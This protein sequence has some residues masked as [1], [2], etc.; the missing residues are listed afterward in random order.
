MDPDIS[1]ESTYKREKM[2]VFDNVFSEDNDTNYVCRQ[3]MLPLLDNVVNGYNATLFAYGMTGAGK[4]H[5]LFGELD[6]ETLRVAKPGLIF[7]TL[8]ELFAKTQSPTFAD[9]EFSIKVS[10]LEIYNE[11][12]RDLLK[13]DDQ[14]LMILEDPQRGVLVADLLESSVS[15]LSE[16]MQLI[17]T[18]NSK[19]TMASTSANTF[20]SRSH[21]IV[22]VLVE[23]KE[24]AAGLKGV[25]LQS[26]LSLID[27]AGSERAAVTENRGIRMLEGANINRSLLALG[28][29]INILS[30]SQK[31]GAFVPYRDSK[32]TRL[33]KDSLGGNTKT[34]MIACVSPSYLCYEETVNTL[35]Y[36]S[37][38]KN[39]K[40]KLHQNVKEVELHVSQYKEII[41]NLKAEIDSL[42]GQLKVKNTEESFI[43][44]NQN[45]EAPSP[46]SLES[47]KALE[48]EKRIDQ[49]SHKIFENLEQN[50]EI[51]QTLRELNELELQN[52][53]TLQNLYQHLEHVSEEDR[54]YR[55]QILRQIETLKTTMDSNE[56]IKRETANT[57]QGNLL[58]NRNL[59]EQLIEFASSVDTLEDIELAKKLLDI[60]RLDM[61]TQ[62]TEI[63]KQALNLAKAR[64][65]QN[66]QISQME[67]EMRQMKA[68]LYEKVNLTYVLVRCLPLIGEASCF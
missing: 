54:V 21:A 66:K 16:V 40:R 32:L 53:D 28:N 29:C 65:Q 44:S 17:M 13:G 19:R 23:R 49:A 55:E 14:N 5:T 2:Y 8:E 61:M 4:T 34:I 35:K 7:L 68:M 45:N 63:K 41:E 6:P 48:E 58:E 43:P 9:Y 1:T 52:K 51:N 30:D 57:L 12:V 46:Q 18:G 50:W 20:S 11:Q 38:A 10:Y 47:S 60:D 56:R 22:Q 3:T 25:V 39:I 42:K 36:A 67:E 26:K 24:R 37:R 64:V 15:S 27:L 31:K 59:K 33:L 62:N